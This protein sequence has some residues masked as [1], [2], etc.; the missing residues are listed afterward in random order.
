MSVAFDS[1]QEHCR[2]VG[3]GVAS[4]KS[5]RMKKSW[6]NL[7]YPNY[8]R[9]IANNHD[10]SLPGYGKKNTKALFLY[11]MLPNKRTHLM[12]RGS[13]AYWLLYCISWHTHSIIKNIGFAYLAYT[14]IIFNGFTTLGP[15]KLGRFFFVGPY[16]TAFWTRSST[17]PRVRWSWVLRC[18]SWRGSVGGNLGLC[19]P[20]WPRS[21]RLFGPLPWP[22]PAGAWRWWW[23]LWWWSTA[24]SRWGMASGPRC[25]SDRSCWTCW[26]MVLGG[27]VVVNWCG[28]YGWS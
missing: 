15:Y 16:G 11:Y 21:L 12:K 13:I 28:E 8:P 17:R 6:I 9:I 18:H 22:V 23:C 4:L 10:D 5:K 24:C 3:K 7:F 26:W 14:F 25:P 1:V 20:C 2:F 19:R 27:G